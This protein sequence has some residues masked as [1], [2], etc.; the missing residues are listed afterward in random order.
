MREL[1]WAVP[2]LQ[3]IHILAIAVVLSSLLMIELRVYRRTSQ[4]MAD[5]AHRFEAWIWGGLVV[6]AATGTTQILAE[7][8][9]TLPNVS[10]QLKI[11][12]LCLA[13]ATTFAMRMALRRNVDFG[14]SAGK[15][16]GGTKL[17]ALIVFVLWCG[18]A[19]AGRFIAYTQPS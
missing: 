6:L 11:V 4:S 17:L 13:V 12:L 18:V 8:Q 1:S 10:F 5:T 15:A 7:P 14:M 2:L 19:T 3:T 16:T 9:R